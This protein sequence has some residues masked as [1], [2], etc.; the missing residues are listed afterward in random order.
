MSTNSIFETS[1]G[2]LRINEET[3]QLIL[4]GYESS[5]VTISDCQILLVMGEIKELSLGCRVT[6]RQ[7]VRGMEY[8]VQINYV[9]IGAL[10]TNSTV[11]LDALAHEILAFDVTP[12]TLM[13]DDLTK[14]VNGQ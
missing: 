5:V 7:I 9:G 12:K 1:P 14:I 6:E 4:T 10:D 2:P 11:K 8:K 3:I 13:I